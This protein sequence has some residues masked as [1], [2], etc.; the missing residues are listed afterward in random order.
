MGTFYRQWAHEFTNLRNEFPPGTRVRVDEP[1]DGLKFIGTVVGL[2]PSDAWPGKIVVKFESTD[3]AATVETMKWHGYECF[4]I[5]YERSLLRGGP[6]NVTKIPPSPSGESAARKR[7]RKERD[8][9]ERNTASIPPYDIL[10]K[11]D[12]DALPC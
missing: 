9:G 4:V 11:G 2:V 1:K 5:D 12:A 7:V 3:D 6:K 8:E 10:A